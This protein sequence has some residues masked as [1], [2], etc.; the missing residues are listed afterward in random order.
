MFFKMP[1]WLVASVILLAGLAAGCSGVRIETAAVFTPAPSSTASPMAATVTP[2]RL[3][4]APDFLEYAF[5]ASLD[6]AKRYLF[7][8]HGKIIED[9]G[10]PAVSPEYG[11]YEYAAILKKFSGFGFVV[12]SE[13]RPKN[14]DSLAYA[15]KIARQVSGLLKAGVPAKN[16]TVVGASKGAGIAVEVSRQLENPSLNYVILAICDPANVAEFLQ[17]QVILH[18]NVLSIYDSVDE[19]GGSCQEL[20]DFSEGKGLTRSAELV[21]KVG[22]GHG[23]L[24][25][26]LDDWIMPVVDWANKP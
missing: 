14:T 19:N 26:P 20:F 21:L 10:I 25:K 13:P 23:L 12:I 11:E 4:P 3:S 16:V 2:Y 18:G 8:L 9:Q 1:G 22:T 24:Y 17:N 15:G 7:Y 5:P 6:P